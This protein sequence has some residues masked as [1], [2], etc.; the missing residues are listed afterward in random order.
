MEDE[1]AWYIMFAH[2]NIQWGKL[3]ELNHTSEVWRQASGHEGFEY[4]EIELNIPN[5]NLAI[6]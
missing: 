5:V 2:N 3:E 4:I 1:V 6:I